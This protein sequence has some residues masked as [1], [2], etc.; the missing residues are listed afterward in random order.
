MPCEPYK[1]AL[2]EAITGGVEPHGELRTHLD[3]CAVCRTAFEEER[4]LYASMDAGL[5]FV[6]NAEVPASLLPRV[7]ARLDAEPAR[8]RGW[9]ANW[10]VLASAAAIFAG[11]FVARTVWRQ[12]I[13]ENPS[14]NSAEK[15]SPTPAIDVPHEDK[16]SSKRFAK[17]NPPSARKGF[18]AEHSSNAG[19]HAAHRSRP[20]VIVP[21]DQ[22]V[23]LA[24]Y[25]EQWHRSKHAPLLAQDS[26]ATILAPLEVAQ[27]Q[28]AELDVKLLAG[29]KSQ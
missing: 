12:T 17:N 7:R 22:E 14:T 2:N 11:I 6:A 5:R 18:V 28:I 1:E 4:A 21:K 13:R 26:S 20:E 9:A 8:S 24:E 25:A 16:Q 10:L 23:L 29:E 27:I 15:T 19:I 3:G